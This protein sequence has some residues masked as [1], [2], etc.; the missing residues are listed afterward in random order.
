MFCA[1]LGDIFY[2]YF[3]DIWRLAQWPTTVAMFEE[4]RCEHCGGAVRLR[5]QREP[6]A[7]SETAAVESLAVGAAASLAFRSIFEG[8]IILWSYM[9]LETGQILQD[10]GLSAT[11][12]QLWGQNRLSGGYS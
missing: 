10:S 4:R 6:H 11:I 5:W 8:E 1:A 7:E 9:S 2:I 3:E 12:S